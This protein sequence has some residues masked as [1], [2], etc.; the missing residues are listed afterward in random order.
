MADLDP[1]R[2]DLWL[3]PLDDQRDSQLLEAYRQLLSAEE[4]RRL[5]RFLREPDRHRYLVTRAL[6][7]TVLARFTGVAPECLRFKENRY[8]KPA[9]CGMDANNRTLSFNLS[10][11][12]DMIVLALTRDR[13]LGVDVENIALRPAPINIAKRFFAEVEVIDLEELSTAA[14]SERF[15]ELW[16]LKE[17]YVKA[18]GM[19][20]SIPLDQF[21]FRFG[22]CGRLAMWM[23]PDLG[24]CPSRWHH[25]QIR[26]ASKYLVAVCAE[27]RTAASSPSITATRIIPLIGD[28]P[29]GHLQLRTCEWQSR[30]DFG[31]G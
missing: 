6:V 22:A 31:V 28:E 10:H 20:L 15:F 12:G 30:A 29:I 18:R 17:A 8:G 7:R 3:T 14:Q 25:W 23:E 5:Q 2:I 24:D 26:I 27:H 19:G 21:G 13:E 4:R 11:C 1:Q 16:T 9:L